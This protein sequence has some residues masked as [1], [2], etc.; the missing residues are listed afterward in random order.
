MSKILLHSALE[1]IGLGPTVDVTL[2]QTGNE[3]DN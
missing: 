1:P 2:R 3:P